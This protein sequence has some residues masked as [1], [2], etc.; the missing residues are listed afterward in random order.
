LKRTDDE[1][2]QLLQSAGESAP[3]SLVALADLYAVRGQVDPARELF[4]RESR[5]G[6]PDAALKLGNLLKDRFDDDAG[7]EQA[8][9]RGI[10][11]G[12]PNSAFNLGLLLD[13]KGRHAEAISLFEEAARGGDDT[14]ASW[15]AERKN[16][17]T[18]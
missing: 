10:S 7:A 5:Q 9:R 13:E 11:L 15:L 8:Y 6:N 16:P 1:T 2:L 4:E 14:A 17:V 3:E 18:D 12:D